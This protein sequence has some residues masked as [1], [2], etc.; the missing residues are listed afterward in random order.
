LFSGVNGTEGTLRVLNASDLSTVIDIPTPEGY[1]KLAKSPD[2]KLWV[3]A[4]TSSEIAIVDMASNTL[5]TVLNTNDFNNFYG[6]YTIAFSNATITGLNENRTQSSIEI[7]PNPSNG[8]F[9]IKSKVEIKSIEI[10]TM[11]GIVMGQYETGLKNQ[12][13]DFNG[14]EGAYIVK[15]TDTDG[16]TQNTTI[17]VNK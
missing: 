11:N 4:G 14:P 10:I 7:F 12:R 2:Q 3:P 16:N 8:H 5:E 9:N 1:G 17:M 15:I 6:P 13:I